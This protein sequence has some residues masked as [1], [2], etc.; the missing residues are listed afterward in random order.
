MLIKFN[1]GHN[2]EA[3]RLYKRISIQVPR[4]L[5]I[6]ESG[7]ITPL[8]SFLKAVFLSFTVVVNGLATIVATQSLQLEAVSANSAA[9]SILV[10]VFYHN[11]RCYRRRNYFCS[12]FV[13]I[14]SKMAESN[15]SHKYD[16]IVRNFKN[17]KYQNSLAFPV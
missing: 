4:P 8:S 10:V 11:Y 7:E 5:R 2:G 17:L 16:V 13:W 9:R 15:V 12:V 3:K 14:S 6:P 1:S